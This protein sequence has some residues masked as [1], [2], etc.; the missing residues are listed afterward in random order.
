LAPV[1]AVVEILFQ[2]PITLGHLLFTNRQ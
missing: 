2:L 1:L